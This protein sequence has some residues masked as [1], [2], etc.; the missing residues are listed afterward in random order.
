MEGNGVRPLK[1]LEIATA[2]YWDVAT[3]ALSGSLMYEGEC[4]LF[5]DDETHQLYMPVWPMG[6]SFNGSA[7]LFHHPGKADQWIAVAQEIQISGQPLDWARFS[8]RPYQ[9]FHYQCGAYQPFY[10]SS[11]T[12]AD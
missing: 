1:P 11:I 9:P 8:T 6:S 12:P 4:L 2:P 3:T 5:R 7:L 10:V